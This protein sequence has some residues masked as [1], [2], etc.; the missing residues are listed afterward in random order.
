MPAEPVTKR[1]VQLRRNN[2]ALGIPTT[3]AAGSSGT[4][5][6]EDVMGERIEDL[7]FIATL[8]FVVLCGS[9]LGAVLR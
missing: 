3:G 7:K 1:T 6:F 8:A 9:G 5:C 4:D 2:E